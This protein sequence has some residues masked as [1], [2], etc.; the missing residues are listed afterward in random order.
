MNKKGLC[1]LLG[2]IGLVSMQVN[3]QVCEQKLREAQ[4]T[5]EKGRIDEVP[6]LLED[7]LESG[8]TKEQQIAAYK[9]LVLNYLYY[10]EKKKAE[11]AMTFFLKLNPEYKAQE[12]IDPPEFINLYNTF[13]TR[14]VF[15]YSPRAGVN[16]PYIEE[17]V[18][19]SVDNDNIYDG[20]YTP[21]VGFQVGMVIEIPIRRVSIEPGIFYTVTKYSFSDQLLN[22]ADIKFDETQAS[23][24]VPLV[25]RYKFGKGRVK[26]FVGIGGG[27][28]YLISADASIVRND[29]VDTE[30]TNREV[31][32]SDYDMSQQRN[33]L[34]FYA[35][36]SLGTTIKSNRN[37]GSWNIDLQIHYSFT[38]VVNSQNRTAD[39]TLMYSY[40]YIDNDFKMH[41]VLLNIAYSIPVYK[42]KIITKK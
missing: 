16:V 1:L 34:G 10:N 15:L 39:P 27:L 22:Y 12:G 6:A 19:Y 29:S 9:L 32:R 37:T 30:L 33:S 42:P 20:A 18:R 25:A 26:P 13:R 4:L 21:S 7:C 23:V 2:L 40:G 14:P 28:R 5:Y 8:F 24:N 41:A 11:E 17:T 35:I 36:G 31:P 38:D 3:G